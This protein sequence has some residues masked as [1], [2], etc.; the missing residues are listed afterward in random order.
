MTQVVALSGGIGSG[1][2]TVR[3]IL[4][5]LGA[6]TICADA[7][8]HA[9]QVPG[10]GLLEEI[11]E[12]FGSEVIGESGSLDRPALARVVF[13]DPEARGRLGAIMHPPVIAEMMR[14]AEEGVEAGAALVV[15]DIPLYFEGQKTGSGS[16]A[17]RQYDASILVW[18][19]RETQ[20]LRT[21]SR[22]GCESAEAERRIAAQMPIDEKRAYAT[23]II[24]NSGDR[25]ATRRQVKRV[26]EQLAHPV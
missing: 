17:A 3:E 16:A 13:R 8:V 20:I 21:V 22:D 24:D 15:L 10:T 11:A 2:T 25:E 12:A 6:V 14:R 18:V 5:E 19:P 1:K 9:L 7:I 26:F 23:H 4:D